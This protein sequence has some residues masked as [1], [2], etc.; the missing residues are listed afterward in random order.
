MVSF[1]CFFV[2]FLFSQKDSESDYDEP[3]EANASQLVQSSTQSSSRAIDLTSSNVSVSSPN[4]NFPMLLE[5]VKKEIDEELSE[6]DLIDMEMEEI[7]KGHDMVD[8]KS[9][10]LDIKLEDGG[11]F[12]QDLK[13]VLEKSDTELNI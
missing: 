6:L 11:E 1:F 10:L 4:S 3:M 9:Q 5:N 13:D 2:L 7:H 8:C 12:A